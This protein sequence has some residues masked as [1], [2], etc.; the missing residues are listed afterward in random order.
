MLGAW[1]GAHLGLEAIPE[2]WCQRLR[3]AERISRAVEKIL[4]EVDS[5][6]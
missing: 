3:Y 2:E 4:R 1:L 5:R 6:Q